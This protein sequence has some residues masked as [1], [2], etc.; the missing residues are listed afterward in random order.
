M[1]AL[2]GRV[3]A[4]IWYRQSSK[5]VKNLPSRH[6]EKINGLLSMKASSR[7][8][9]NFSEVRL[10]ATPIVMLSKLISAELCFYLRGLR[11]ARDRNRNKPMIRFSQVLL[12]LIAELPLFE[13]P[14]K[15]RI[16]WNAEETTPLQQAYLRFGSP[17]DT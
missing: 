14:N 10:K 8:R 1:H 12:F 11:L 13:W 17:S 4:T 7:K 15:K 9:V 16:M 3:W 6:D 2:L 5:G